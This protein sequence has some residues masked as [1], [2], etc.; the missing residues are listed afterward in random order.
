MFRLLKKVGGLI[1][2]GVEP[3]TDESG[4]FFGAERFGHRDKSFLRN[5]KCLIFERTQK[6]SK[7]KEDGNFESIFAFFTK[8]SAISSFIT[9][10]QTCKIAD[11]YFCN[12]SF[13]NSV[14]IIFQASRFIFVRFISKLTASG[15]RFGIAGTKS[16]LMTAF[17]CVLGLNQSF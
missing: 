8:K 17:F 7:I 10:G 13:I 1:E 15:I 6:N 4:V 12:I 3:E 5:C 16:V 2:T 9:S 14:L 11:L